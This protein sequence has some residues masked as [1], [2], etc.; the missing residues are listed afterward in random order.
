[1]AGPAHDRQHGNGRSVM[2]W[3]KPRPRHVPSTR[4]LEQR[5]RRGAAIAARK[6][7]QKE[8]LDPALARLT[9]FDGA[10]RKLRYP[11]ETSLSSALTPSSM[12]WAR[13]S[14]SGVES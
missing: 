13:T 8:S 12:P 5:G 9:H 6:K 1:M 2:S 11:I 10:V 4:C 3:A 14:R 7:A